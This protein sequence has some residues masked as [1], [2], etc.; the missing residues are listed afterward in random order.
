ML[1][2]CQ[3]CG[4]EL[5]N[6]RK[7]EEPCPNCDH[8]DPIGKDKSLKRRNRWLALPLL[9]LGLAIVLWN[10]EF[11]YIPQIVDHIIQFFSQ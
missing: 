5:S 9:I 3:E 1:I 10:V 2:A 4:Y 6:Q 11:T 8:P 7:V